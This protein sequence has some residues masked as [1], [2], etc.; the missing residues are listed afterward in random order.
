MAD[1]SKISWTERTW[2]VTGGCTEYSIGCCGCYARGL[3]WRLAHQ[4]G[5]QYDKYRGLV[6]KING[7]LRWTGKIVLFDEHLD[8]PVKRKI[9]TT[10]F[11]DSR[12]DL[13]HPDVPFEFIEN[14][15]SIIGDCPQHTFQILTKRPEIMLE[16]FNSLGKQFELSC[17][18]NLHLGVTVEHPDY[19]HRI[20]TLLQIPAARRFVSVEPMLGRVKLPRLIM[21]LSYD[22]PGLPY[23]DWVIIGCESGSNRRP[24]K[25]E[26]V[27]SIVEQCKAA[28]VSIFVKQLDINGKVEKDI[29]N[30]P[31]DLRVREIIK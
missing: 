13:F 6:K 17:M 19:K 12:S 16:Y 23:I 14:V 4:T 30:F 5:K 8:Q 20:S 25:L 21:P 1:K 28:G 22:E 7:K 29:S 26:W 2:E 10:Y 3:I 27:R 11:V 18:S 24:C 9:P 31:A 15:M